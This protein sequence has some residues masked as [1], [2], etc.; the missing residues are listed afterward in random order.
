M[1]AFLA[2]LA[3]GLG[4][5]ISK[6]PILATATACVVTFFKDLI[7][8]FKILAVSFKLA[9]SVAQETANVGFVEMLIAIFL[10]SFAISTYWKLATAKAI[11]AFV[12]SVLLAADAV[13]IC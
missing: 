6:P 5:L 12:I 1:L 3:P 13:L 11:T 8:F 2:L 10:Q 9:S 4:N 7:L